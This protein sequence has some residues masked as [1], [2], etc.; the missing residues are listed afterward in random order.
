M[1]TLA[2]AYRYEHHSLRGR[3]PLSRKERERASTNKSYSISYSL[4]IFDELWECADPNM[5]DTN[6][7]GR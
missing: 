1:L 3:S 6:D 4:E 5:R 2:E 7:D